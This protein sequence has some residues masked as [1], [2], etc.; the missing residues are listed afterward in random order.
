MQE[1]TGKV[2]HLF[3]KAHHGVPMVASPKLVV[4]T[5]HGIEEDV[6]AHAMSPRQILFV[7]QEDLDEFNI[8]PGELRE[9]VAVS[10]IHPDFF[11]LGATLIIGDA[12]NIRATFLCEACKRIAHVVPSLK[13]IVNK[14][15]LL[16]VIL[17]D[18]NIRVDSP[19]LVRTHQFPALSDVPYSRFLAFIAKIPPGRVITYR[20]VVIGMG[21]AESYMRAIPMY[22]HRTSPD[23]YPLHRILDTE[24]K[25]IP[26]VPNQQSLLEAE[27]VTLVQAASLFDDPAEAFVPLN[28]YLWHD[29]TV[30]LS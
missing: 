12:V 20:Q 7:R 10:G 21:V 17:S 25:V 27:K 15:G 28:Q 5:G 4:K 6:N 24:G 1:V 30:Y 22:I 9:N 13:S 26:Y 29:P 23:K 14:R 3:M 16:G 2:T 19:V 18:G 8:T 11:A